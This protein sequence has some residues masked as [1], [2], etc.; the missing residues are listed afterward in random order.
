MTQIRGQILFSLLASYASGAG[1]HSPLKDS[2]GDNKP[3]FQHGLACTTAI[4]SAQSLYPHPSS[5]V[6]SLSC[7]PNLATK[8]CF[9]GFW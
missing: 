1:W 9:C 5:R 2:F 3:C 4:S 8:I 7:V 6:L